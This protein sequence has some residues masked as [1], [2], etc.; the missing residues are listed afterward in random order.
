MIDIMDEYLIKRE[1]IFREFDIFE[2]FIIWE[3]DK[4][5]SIVGLKIFKLFKDYDNFVDLLLSEF[6]KKVL[7]L[8]LNL[9]EKK[10]VL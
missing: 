10:V 7:E 2:K 3:F 1:F 5:E 9:K 4:V 8:K 6:E